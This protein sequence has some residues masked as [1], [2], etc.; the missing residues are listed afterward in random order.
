MPSDRDRRYG[1]PSQRRTT[2]T[3]GSTPYKYSLSGSRS[4]STIM[5]P[6]R[7]D[8]DNLK[9][10]KRSISSRSASIIDESEEEEE[11]PN[12]YKKGGYHPVQVGELYKDGRYKVIR[13][14]GWGHFS[15]VWLIQDL[16]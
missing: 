15:T 3:N 4:D 16:K 2:K 5:K 11:D 10:R 12:D 13:K 6:S 14:L 1:R 7:S 8:R 9:K